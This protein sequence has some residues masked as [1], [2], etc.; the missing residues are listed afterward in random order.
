MCGLQA[1]DAGEP[2]VRLGLGLEAREGGGPRAAAGGCRAAA[3]R[4][5]RPDSSFLC[6]FVP[7]WPSTDWMMPTTLGRANQCT[8]ST[9]PIANFI[10]KHPH[11]RNDV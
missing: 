3:G 6:P 5:G 4:Q 9:D 1:A 10:Q 11:G 7:L 2:G 8:E